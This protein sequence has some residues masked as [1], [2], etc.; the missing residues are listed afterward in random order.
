MSS[1]RVNELNTDHD[2]HT[3]RVLLVS[4]VSQMSVFDGAN[5]VED[6]LKG[7]YGEDVFQ[8]LSTSIETSGSTLLTKYRVRDAVANNFADITLWL[9]PQAESPSSQLNR[10]RRGH[11]YIPRQG[12][13]RHTSSTKRPSEV[14]LTINQNR[15][16]RVCVRTTMRVDTTRSIIPL[17]DSRLSP[18][19]KGL[20]ANAVNMCAQQAPM[21]D[22]TRA[23]I[24]SRISTMSTE[25]K[26]YLNG[27]VEKGKVCVPP[28]PPP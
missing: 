1:I 19:S 17:T 14:P 20:I 13:T 15:C 6:I 12:Q 8:R 18:R 3:E 4:D 22:V 21:V 26:K 16:V 2:D 7:K 5:M 24:Y 9:R 11:A 10:S 23:R 28:S 27:L 25:R